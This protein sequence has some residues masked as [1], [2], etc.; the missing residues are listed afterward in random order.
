[1]T[2][3]HPFP[4]RMAPEIVLE[5]I[6]KLKLGQRVLDPM[7]GSGM[8]LSTAARAGLASYG[9]DLD[10]LAVLISNVASTKIDPLDAIDALYVL[11]EK[12]ASI[13]KEEIK[14]PWIDSDQETLTFISYWFDQAQ[15]EQ[16]RS[17]SYYLIQKPIQ[18]NK[19]IRNVLITSL[20][21]LIITKEPKASLA[22]DTA[23]SRPHRVIKHNAY[24]IFE[25]LPESLN[26]VLTALK[27]ECIISDSRTSI[28]DARSLNFLND[29]KFD[30]IITSP[31]Y[32]NAIDYMRG[33]K[34]SLV[35]LGFTLAELRKIRSDSIGAEKVIAIDK[36]KYFSKILS[37]LKSSIPYEPTNLMIQRY[38]LDLYSQLNECFRV[39]KPNGEATY[40]IGN[41]E[42]KGWPICNSEMLK[43]VAN[44]SGFV[45]ISEEKREIPDNRRYMPINLK[46]NSSISK[47]MR[48]EHIISFIKP[49]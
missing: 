38:F 40:V 43:K 20:S 25:S 7:V 11:L 32:L 39:L 44:L 33:H 35:W 22:R 15:I 13:K 41:C 9:V 31:P 48:T 14:L 4:A 27:P 45:L 1:M 23:H 21:R 46:Y 36:K 30:A 26:Y 19:N 18:F 28:G 2:Y 37:E 17:L 16:L 29:E 34:F 49:I 6:G 24:D 8:V 3:I 42:I 12:A 10:P 5:K 47:R